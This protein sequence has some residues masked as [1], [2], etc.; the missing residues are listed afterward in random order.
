MY[1]ATN[2]NNCRRFFRT[3]LKELDD[4]LQGGLPTGC[5]TEVCTFVYTLN[6]IFIFKVSS[7]MIQRRAARF[8]FNKYQW[9]L[10]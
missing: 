8:V 6:L 9:T 2:E 5:I 10:M 4:V 7:T 1:S 3:S